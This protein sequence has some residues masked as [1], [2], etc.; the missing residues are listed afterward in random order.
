MNSC[1]LASTMS[2]DTPPKFYT[3]DEV[4]ARLRVSRRTLQDHLRVHPYGRRLGRRRLFSESEIQQLYEA[5]PCPS[6]STENAA[7]PTGTSAAPSEASL[8]TRAAALL[9]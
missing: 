4:A 5:L 9:K 6:N 3:L 7:A 1:N 8:W 2:P